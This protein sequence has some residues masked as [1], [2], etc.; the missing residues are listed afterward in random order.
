MGGT[1][2]FKKTQSNIM[3][4]VRFIK[5]RCTNEDFTTSIAVF[6]RA[7]AKLPNSHMAMETMRMSIS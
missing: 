7:I 1:I 4:L 6:E 3:S 2:T 5:E